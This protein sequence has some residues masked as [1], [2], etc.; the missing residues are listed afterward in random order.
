MGQHIG[1]LAAILSSTLGGMAGAVTRFVIG[2]TDPVTLAFFRFGVGFLLLLPVALATRARWPQKRDRIGVALLGLMFFSLFF[3]IYNAA[4]RYT[5]AARGALALSMLPLV[6]M[7]VAALLGVERLTARKTAGVLVAMGGVVLALAAGLAGAPEGAWR[8][9]LIM[10]GGTLC[11]AL[12]SVWSRPF[13]Q[14]SSRLGFLTFGMGAGGIASAAIAAAG[15]G[16]AVVAGFGWAQWL[17]VAYL[18]VFGG[19]TAFYLWVF[20]LEHTTPTRVANTMTVNPVAAALLAAALIG[21]PLGLNLVFGVLAV[22][23]GIWLASSGPQAS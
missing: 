11:M 20:A 21:E 7:A 10:A 9:D 13:V 1:V 3:V 15:G 6:T 19:A 5:T 16:I 2:A 22:A 8:G 23:A 4:M 12:Y 17:A 14:R 18:A